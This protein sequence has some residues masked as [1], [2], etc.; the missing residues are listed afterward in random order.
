MMTLVI[1]VVI[2]SCRI[3]EPKEVHATHLTP[4]Q[5]FAALFKSGGSIM[6]LFVALSAVTNMVTWL[7]LNVWLAESMKGLGFDLTT[8]LLFVFSLTG[9]AV[10][11]SFIAAAAADRFGS[12]SV[13]VI[14][15]ALTLAGL[16][17]IVAGPKSLPTALLFVALMGIG[18]HSTQNLINA[19][20]SG[21][22]VA[23]SRGTI[24]GLTNAM[25]FIGS[26][27]GPTLGGTAFAANGPAGV[28]GLYI[29]SAALCLLLC[30]G[31][32]VAK[33]S[34]TR[35]AAVSTEER[36]WAVG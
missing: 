9:A 21:S 33:R 20:A 30:S 35:R 22:V 2:L 28:F 5:K 10:L 8:A 1:L 4:S 18:G 6:V 24:L 36:S 19:T 12:A 7:G 31:L 13:T 11:G 34:Q 32:Y 23:H 3:S 25:A 14:C 26:F 27:L 29:V 17:G 16:I 15:A